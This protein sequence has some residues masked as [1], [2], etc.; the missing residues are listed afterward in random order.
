M[1]TLPLTFL[2]Q[3]ERLVLDL[4][5]KSAN[6]KESTITTSGGEEMNPSEELS[7]GRPL[8]QTTVS[9]A[10]EEPSRKKRRKKAVESNK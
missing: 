1:R 10:G 8:D 7:V 5:P 9:D 2:K 6:A 3:C 4:A